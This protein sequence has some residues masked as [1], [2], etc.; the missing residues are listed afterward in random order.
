MP[1]VCIKCPSLHLPCAI[2][3]V[4]A[5]PKCEEGPGP[6][7]P[8]SNAKIECTS[9]EPAL[10]VKAAVLQNILRIISYLFFKIS[11]QIYIILVVVRN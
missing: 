7:C 6:Q 2:T 1:A 11:L 4:E 3:S 9:D 10:C 8:Y 5:P